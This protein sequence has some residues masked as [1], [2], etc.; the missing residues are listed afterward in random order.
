[1]K[2]WKTVLAAF[3]DVEQQRKN[4]VSSRVGDPDGGY[5]FIAVGA[6]SFLTDLSADGLSGMEA[7]RWL[8]GHYPHSDG[9]SKNPK[10]DLVPRN[11][12]S[13]GSVSDPRSWSHAYQRW[14]KR[15][16]LARR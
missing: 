1:M 9:F 15:A 11:V 2:D 4:W 13:P 5:G 16:A 12:P 7:W 14:E 8:R 10:W 6:A 3:S